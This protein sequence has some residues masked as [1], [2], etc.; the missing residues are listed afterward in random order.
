[1]IITVERESEGRLSICVWQF[2]LR[3]RCGDAESIALTQYLDMSRPSR[4]HKYRSIRWWHYL[5]KRNS[6]IPRDQI[7][8]PPD[9][10]AEAKQQIVDAVQKLEVV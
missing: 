9:V 8:M 6:K 10:V 1:M 2:D 4:K 3:I 5:D 7:P